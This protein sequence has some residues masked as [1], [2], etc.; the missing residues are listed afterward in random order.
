MTIIFK[1]GR[2]P[3]SVQNYLLTAGTLYVMDD[4]RREIPV[5]ELDLAAT[6]KVNREAGI[7]FRLP[8]RSK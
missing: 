1:D 6:A 3:V 8:G 4:R 2:P 5:V 7:D